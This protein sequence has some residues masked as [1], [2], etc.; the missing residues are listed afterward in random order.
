[1]ATVDM[2]GVAPQFCGIVSAPMGCDLS[3]RRRRIVRPDDWASNA[4]NRLTLHIWPSALSQSQK[5]FI[6]KIET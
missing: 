5:V 6:F 4:W 3:N 1:M 2:P